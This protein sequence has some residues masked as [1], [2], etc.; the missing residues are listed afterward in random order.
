MSVRTVAVFALLSGAAAA[1]E[2]LDSPHV[3]LPFDVG[4]AIVGHFDLDELPDIAFSTSTA[5]LG[6]V[7][8]V[9]PGGTGELVSYPLPDGVGLPLG[10]LDG[11]GLD[12]LASWSVTTGITVFLAQ[13]PGVFIRGAVLAPLHPLPF[14]KLAVGD[15][16]DD[17]LADLVLLQKAHQRLTLYTATG[18][19]TFA[20]P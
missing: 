3:A 11:N 18:P 1:Q 6:H 16:D 12:D 2:L 13:S 17:G 7:L 5:T 4:S 10:D 8:A 9:I 14:E 15:A 20:P 19:G